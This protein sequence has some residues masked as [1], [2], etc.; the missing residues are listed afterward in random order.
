MNLIGIDPG[1]T[2][3]YVEAFRSD[4]GLEILEAKEIG[5]EE[6]FSLIPLIGAKVVS[7][8][9]VSTILVVESFV[10]FDHEFRHQVGSHFPSVR[11][12][13]IVEAAAWLANPRPEIIFQSASLKQRV[14][15]VHDLPKGSEHVRDAYR[16]IRYYHESQRL[17]K[18]RV[19]SK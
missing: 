11:V 12:I 13:G 17:A 1:Q 7:D 14:Q 4:D 18:R 19:A 15:I 3:G 8:P 5:W 6:R 9:L 10:L 16:H 2:T